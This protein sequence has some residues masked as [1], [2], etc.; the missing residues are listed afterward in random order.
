VE[1]VSGPDAVGGD[2]V[3]CGGFGYPCQAHQDALELGLEQPDALGQ[4]AQREAG[5]GG[6]AVVV[7][8]DAE[9]RA[10]L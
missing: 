10:G 7:K 3:W 9:R 4:L 5:D 8:T 1:A 6:Q 2:H